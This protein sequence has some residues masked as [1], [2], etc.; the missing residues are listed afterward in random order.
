MNW[1][2]QAAL[3]LV[4]PR[5]IEVA[6]A[7]LQSPQDQNWVVYDPHSASEYSAQQPNSGRWHLH[8]PHF[9]LKV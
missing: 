6:E 2:M 9:A 8:P 7:K 5:A 3:P 1:A 4:I